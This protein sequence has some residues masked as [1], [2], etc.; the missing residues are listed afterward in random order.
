MKEILAIEAGCIPRNVASILLRDQNLPGLDQNN[1]LVGQK[2]TLL[3]EEAL[4]RLQKRIIAEAE[5]NLRHYRDIKQA[6]ENTI[7]ATKS[8][9]GCDDEQCAHEINAWL[10]AFQT[11]KGHKKTQIEQ[12]QNQPRHAPPPPSPRTVAPPAGEI[13]S[14]LTPMERFL[15]YLHCA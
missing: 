11:N 4:T 5:N 7:P 13:L 12:A 15:Y 10:R 2:P 6:R 1:E 8:Q 14:I 3:T 9:C